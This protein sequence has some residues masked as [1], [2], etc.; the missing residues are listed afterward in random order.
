MVGEINFM[1]ALELF[2]W[3]AFKNKEVDPC[4]KEVTERAMYYANG[5][6][7]AWE[8]IGSNLF[9]KTLDEWESTLET[10]ERIPNRDVQE[11]LKDSYDRLE[12]SQQEMF[13]ETTCFFSGRSRRYVRNTL[14]A[15]GGVCPQFGLKVL[16]ER[17]LIKI[18]KCPHDTMEMHHIWEKK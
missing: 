14:E 16:E 8:A 7:L 5:L 18:R 2:K 3:N 10:Y 12:A 11:V 15:R 6:P 9:G 17:S 1:E 4:Y 13:L